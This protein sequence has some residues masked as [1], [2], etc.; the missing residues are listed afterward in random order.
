MGCRAPA[1]A[2]GSSRAQAPTV[3]ATPSGTVQRRRALQA[4]TEPTPMAPQT[5]SRVVKN[6]LV[7]SSRNGYRWSA[8]ATTSSAASRPTATT[9]TAMRPRQSATNPPATT[10]AASGQPPNP[11]RPSASA[12]RAATNEAVGPTPPPSGTKSA[13]QT[14]CMAELSPWAA[15]A[16]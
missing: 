2:A 9:T 6:R 4:T 1:R 13:A 3:T 7:R 11:T 5:V 14:R 8:P 15:K 12:A 16:R 10:A